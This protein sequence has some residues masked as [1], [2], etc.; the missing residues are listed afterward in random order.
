VTLV[1]PGPDAR[2]DL[3]GIAPRSRAPRGTNATLVARQDLGH[4]MARFRFRH[5]DG[6]RSFVAGQYL[7]IGLPDRSVPPRPYSIA[8]GPNSPELDFVISLVAGGALSPALF[9]L[10]VGERVHLG[11]PRGLFLLDDGDARDHLLI[12]TGSGIAPLLSM[13]AALGAR[14]IPPRTVLLHGVRVCDEL[15]GLGMSTHRD[16][17]WLSYRP[18]VSRVAA[19]DIWPGRRGRVGPH[20][21]ALIDGG[22]LAPERT[23]AYLCGNPAM[24]DACGSR[25]S[26][27]GLP[28]DA[29]RTERFVTPSV[30]GAASF[31]AVGR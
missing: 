21:D 5:D 27:A 28:V 26:A 17:R 20:L 7:T 16:R 31:R 19:V 2:P 9:A 10:R 15:A 11:E 25:L 30:D 18:T 29:I 8:C 24:I 6:P 23:A 22:E 3:T 12:G 14:L 1:I 13:V 4:A